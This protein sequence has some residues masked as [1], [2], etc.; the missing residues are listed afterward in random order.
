MCIKNSNFCEQ[1]TWIGHC[2]IAVVMKHENIH[3]GYNNLKSHVLKW[4]DW[5][6]SSD[7]GRVEMEGYDHWNSNGTSLSSPPAGFLAL[8]PAGFALNSSWGAGHSLSQ[9]IIF[10]IRELCGSLGFNFGNEKLPLRSQACPRKHA[11]CQKQLDP[12][13]AGLTSPWELYD[14]TSPW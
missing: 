14:D 3:P 11:F 6:M 7:S 8:P 12:S 13:C 4:F 10:L 5:Q 1:Q 9:K 2:R